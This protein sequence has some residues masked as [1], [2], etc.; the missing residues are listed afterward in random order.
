MAATVGREDFE[1][2]RGLLESARKKTRP[3]RHDVYD[4]FSAIVYLLEQ[5]IPWRNLPP[6][7]PPWRTVHEYFRQWTEQRTG[8]SEVLLEQALKTLH[9]PGLLAA[10]HERLARS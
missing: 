10:L 7:Y 6:S 2:V 3:R 4:V 1:A 9:Q 5:R 8:Q